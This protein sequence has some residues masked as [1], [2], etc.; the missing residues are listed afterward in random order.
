LRRGAVPYA[1]ILGVLCLA[2]AAGAKPPP[3]KAG[4]IPVDLEQLAESTGEDLHVEDLDVSLKG[5][6]VRFT[7]EIEEISSGAA[8]EHVV[9]LAD[10]GDS[11][12]LRLPGP[13]DRAD[14][15]RDEEW[16]VIVRL[17]RRVTLAD[18]RAAIAAAPDI[19]VKTPGPPGVERPDDVVARVAGAELFDEP[20]LE[21]WEDEKPLYR[22]EVT[23]P[24]RLDRDFVIP[25]PTAY[26]GSKGSSGRQL[27]DFRQIMRAADDRQQAGRCVFRVEGGKLRNISFGQVNVAPNGKRSHE[28]WVDFESDQFHDTW[29]AA[30]KSFPV[31]TYHPTCLNLAIS[32]FPFG[33]EG[34]V[35]FFLW[36]DRGMPIPV[37]AFVDGDETVSVAGK[38]MRA[39]RVRIGLDVRRAARQI[40]VPDQWKSEA[41]A[42]GETW[43]AGDATYWI[44]ADDPHRVLRFSGPIGPPGSPEV[45]VER[46]R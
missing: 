23:N 18:G 9:V 25:G 45:L 44:A 40:D 27:Y 26:A 10:G 41:E 22:L 34:V 14:L 37:Y 12:V 16:E 2:A 21:P 32:G 24:G 6:R 19:L 46:V 43:Y 15:D 28:K 8:G 7:G 36:G 33:R 20:K 38:P 5:K 4:T 29:S 30:R 35:R 42:V 11:V 31:N 39:H 1:T 3:P 17:D 13:L